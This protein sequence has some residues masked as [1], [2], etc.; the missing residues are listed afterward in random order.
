MGHWLVRSKEFVCVSLLVVSDPL[1]PH[2]LQPARLP[3]PWNS[4]GK[5]TAVG[6][7]FLLWE[8]KNVGI[9]TAIWRGHYSRVDYS[10]QP[11]A[12]ILTLL[13]ISLLNGG[14]ISVTPHW[15]N[16]LEVSPSELSENPPLQGRL[17]KGVS[18]KVVH[19]K[20]SGG[21]VLGDGTGPWGLVATVPSA[22]RTPE[23]L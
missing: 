12:D 7:H 10:P 11:P 22:S 17:Y 9:L 4:L 21:R 18:P 14:E 19:Y 23:K 5:N 3:G 2:G 20:T 13:K 8:V 6:C 15:Q 1:R 16:F